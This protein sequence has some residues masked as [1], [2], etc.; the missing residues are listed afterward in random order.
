[1]FAAFGYTFC[2]IA[3]FGITI[4]FALLARNDWEFT[5]P[6]GEDFQRKVL[7]QWKQIG[8][9]GGFLGVA[10]YGIAPRDPMLHA[11]LSAIWRALGGHS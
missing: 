5:V 6:L 9:V 4:L 8:L 7:K 1:M 3:G 2:F 11:L 10:Y